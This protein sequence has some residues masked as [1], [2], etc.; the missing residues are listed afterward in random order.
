MKAS[1][2]VLS[3]FAAALLVGCAHGNAATEKELSRLRGQVQRLQQSRDEDRRRLEAMEAQLAAMVRRQQEQK[4]Q[5]RTEAPV[6]QPLSG[7]RIEPA[8]VG[9]PPVEEGEDS[10]IFIV[11]RGGGEETPTSRPSRHAR[12]GLPVASGP[13]VDKAPPLPTAIE[14]K[15]P[16][17]PAPSGPDAFDDG[18]AALAANDPAAAVTHLE[19]F[20]A[21]APRD[22]RADNAGL[23]LGEAFALQQMPGRAL[24]AWE[25]V[26][27]DYTAGD[28][29]PDA[30]LRYGETCRTLGRG[31]AAQ[32]AFERLV[33]DYP[34]T[35]A[36]ARA[37]VYLAEGK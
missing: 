8:P 21:S 35:E 1:T 32:A 10:F 37:G 6:P 30:L 25:R 7:V 3:A 5:E 19:R 16:D 31:A 36:A 27:T 33:R 12:R 20:L 23:A 9:A 22:R 15:E 13:G 18:V 24:Q 34:G 28:A 2:P 26:A 11:D 29:V 14:I 17:A 4:Q